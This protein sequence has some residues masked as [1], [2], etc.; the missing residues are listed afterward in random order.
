[1][2]ANC[3]TLMDFER[4]KSSPYNYNQNSI[5][6]SDIQGSG[7]KME[8]RSKAKAADL[9]SLDIQWRDKEMPLKVV[10]NRETWF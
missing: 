1:M 2:Q 10:A 5:L 6:C 8:R 7:L 3:L 9:Y 4:K